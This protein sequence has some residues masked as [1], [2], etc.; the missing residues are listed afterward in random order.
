MSAHAVISP[1]IADAVSIRS[2]SDFVEIGLGDVL[3]IKDR[4]EHYVI[5]SKYRAH[6]DHV[7]E[8]EGLKRRY[9]V[10]EPYVRESVDMTHATER[11]RA[12]SYRTYA[13]KYTGLKNDLR[14]LSDAVYRIVIKLRG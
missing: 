13:E 11:V 8:I 14:K 2:L 4:I 6:S 5:I 10:L 1:T 7:Q 12:N 3:H 9:R